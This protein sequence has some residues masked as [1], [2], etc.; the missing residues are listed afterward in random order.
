MAIRCEFLGF[1]LALALLGACTAQP[2]APTTVA[3]PAAALAP[4]PAPMPF[5][6]AALNAGNAVLA[7]TVAAGGHTVVIDPLVNGVTGEQSAST[8]TLGTKLADLARE[9]YPQLEVK[10]FDST[11]VAAAPIVLVGTFTPVNAANQP[12]GPREAYR[13]CLVAA[14]LKSGKIVSKKAVRALPA[15]VDSTPTRM[16]ADSPAWTEDPAIK[17]YVNTCQSTKV[18]DPIPQIYLNG[19]I[20]AAIV[21]QAMEAYDAGRYREALELFENARTTPAGNQLRVYN[22]IYLT[23]TKLGQPERVEAF[24]ELVDYGLKNNR[25][26]VKLLFR[27]AST[28]F[29]SDPRISGDYDMWLRQIADRS[30][31]A[32]ACLQVTGHTSVSGSPVL[33][34]QLSV[35][36]AEY[37]EKRLQSDNPALAGHLIATGE[38]S[39]QNLVGTGADDASDALDRRVEFKVISSC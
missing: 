39:K 19:I 34:E 18:G 8:K 24:G 31:K 21:N 3:A 15:G 9:R 14:D 12:S 22:G 33:N 30:A 7:G 38:G 2:T 1:S 16:F 28:A 6:E 10:P 25:L 32:G 17:A 23:R 26:V 29:V 11:T 36:R 37:V 13:F 5:D 27:P 20:T 35:L 4:L